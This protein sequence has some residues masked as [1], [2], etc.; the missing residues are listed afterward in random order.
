MALKKW[1]D[2][3]EHRGDGQQ[4]QLTIR[5]VNMIAN[6]SRNPSIVEHSPIGHDVL[7][8]LCPPPIVESAPKVR[9]KEN[10]K[11]GRVEEDYPFRVK[12]VVVVGVLK[13]LLKVAIEEGVAGR[14]CASRVGDGETPERIRTE[15]STGVAVILVHFSDPNEVKKSF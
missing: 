5:Q 3:D 6:S 12:W 14:I 2:G 10:R 15:I 1:E 13:L 8:R 7:F 9:Q 11:R 4:D